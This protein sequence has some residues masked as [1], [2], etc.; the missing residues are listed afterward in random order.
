[1][2]V[3]GHQVLLGKKRT[4]EAADGQHLM[5]KLLKR[6]WMFSE[7]ENDN[8]QNGCYLLS[9]NTGSS[10]VIDDYQQQSSFSIQSISDEHCQANHNPTLSRTPSSLAFSD[11]SPCSEVVC[12]TEGSQL[13]H[14]KDFVF[15]GVETLDCSFGYFDSWP[16]EI[17]DIAIPCQASPQ[18]IACAMSS[19]NSSDGSTDD[20]VVLNQQ[21]DKALANIEKEHEVVSKSRVDP[22]EKTKL[23]PAAGIWDRQMKFN[24][25]EEIFVSGNCAPPE[26]NF[27]VPAEMSGHAQSHAREM[28][29]PTEGILENVWQDPLPQ[30]NNFDMNAGASSLQSNSM[31][32]VDHTMVQNRECHSSVYEVKVHLAQNDS[33]KFHNSIASQT[34]GPTSFK[35]NGI[36]VQQDIN[37]EFGL[38]PILGSSLGA[39]RSEADYSEICLVHLLIAG[40]EA[41]AA[42]DMDLASVI[43]VRLKELVSLSGSTMQRVAAYFVDGLQSRI[44]GNSNFKRI[45]YNKS[46]SDLLAAFQILH[47]ISPYIK[48]GHFTANQAILEAVEGEKAVHIVDFEIMEGIQWPPLMQSLASRKGGPPQLRIS[49]LF[50]PY[51]DNG[52]AS[53]QDTGRRLENFAS[54]LNI[55]FSF[56]IVRV[57]NEDEFSVS[58]IKLVKGEAL[59]VNCT[60]HLPHMPHRTASSVS[61][62][63]HS[64]RRLSPTV[65]TLVEEELGC[66][67]MA[68]SSY[69]FEALHHFSAICDSLEACISSETAARMLV[70]RV[71]LAP[72]INNTVMLWSNSSSQSEL[73]SEF[74]TYNWC[75]LVRSVGFKSLPLSYQNLSQAKLL[76]QLYK[77]GFKLDERSNRLLLGWRSKPL[78]AASVWN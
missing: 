52:H 69:F 76:L 29:Y 17:L 15:D 12:P 70:E 44:E 60:L 66:S 33:N 48:F 9:S 64:M 73:G 26:E 16:P 61:S 65:L 35:C 32:Q 75:S 28:P 2:G 54:S 3:Y 71:F 25:L 68:V 41:V 30:E 31:Q 67:T 19:G 55:P 5:P 51:A 18:H 11:C 53:V 6:G 72:R 14:L 8:G 23:A 1:M 78:F 74:A 22:T 58:S 42:R 56:N 7:N 24:G 77:D 20:G 45:S 43:L 4:M 10:E 50:R 59:V 13:D 62:F 21:E 46:P 39:G 57:N 40:A 38:N 27:D 37:K 49:A 36:Q 63:L 47:E 34:P